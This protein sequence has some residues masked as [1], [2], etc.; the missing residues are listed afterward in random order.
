LSYLVFFNVVFTAP[1]LELNPFGY[2]LLF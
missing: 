1:S 2:N